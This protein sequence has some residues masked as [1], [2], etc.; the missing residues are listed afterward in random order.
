ME[1]RVTSSTTTAATTTVLDELFAASGDPVT[2]VSDYGRQFVSEEFQQVLRQSG[3]KHHKLSAPYHPVTNGQAER[4]VQTVKDSQYR[5]AQHSTTKQPRAQLFLNRVLRTRLD[6]VRPDSTKTRITEKQQATFNSTYR[7]FKEGQTVYFI[8]GNT[9]LNRWIPGVIVKRLGNLHYEIQGS[10]KI[11]KC[12]VD[13]IRVYHQELGAPEESVEE[14]V[15]ES[16]AEEKYKQRTHY[17]E[18]PAA[19]LRRHNQQ[20]IPEVPIPTTPPR[21]PP[22]EIPPRGTPPPEIDHAPV[23]PNCIERDYAQ[24]TNKAI[25]KLL[26]TNNQEQGNMYDDNTLGLDEEPVKATIK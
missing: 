7:V 24:G 13:Q 23:E 22:Q 21:T 14:P 5:K 8:S 11:Y 12:H 16:A 3:V 9:R 1:V 15:P 18:Q 4:H 2:V 25:I 19:P 10:D 17:Y 6:L 26:K 20:P